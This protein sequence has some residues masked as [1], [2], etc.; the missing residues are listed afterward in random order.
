MVERDLRMIHSVKSKKKIWVILLLGGFRNF[1]PNINNW[2][3]W[4]WFYFLCICWP[5]WLHL[6]SLCACYLMK[7]LLRWIL[8]AAWRSVEGGKV[9]RSHECIQQR[10]QSG[11]LQTYIP[12]VQDS[13]GVQGEVT[14]A[15]TNIVFK[16]QRQIESKHPSVHCTVMPGRLPA[17][18]ISHLLH[19]K[20]HQTLSTLDSTGRGFSCF[21]PGLMHLH[22][23]P[24]QT[25][26]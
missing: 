22:V 13:I 11:L 8:K 2:H 24:A 5:D 3:C 15:A 6:S 23:F 26:W 25:S 21:S 17:P 16:M 7:L 18:K 1:C 12:S 10:P 9:F 20:Q 14:K 4:H 19:E